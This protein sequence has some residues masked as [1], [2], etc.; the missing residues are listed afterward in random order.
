MIESALKLWDKTK[1]G[2]EYKQEKKITVLN[3][4]RES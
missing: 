1:D 2:I 3:H 4:P